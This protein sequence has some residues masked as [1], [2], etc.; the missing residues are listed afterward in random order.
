MNRIM[1]FI[2]P[3][4]L[5]ILA[6]VAITGVEHWLSA[7]G[8]TEAARQALGRTGIAVPYLT[9]ALI[10]IV[11]LFASAGAIRGRTNSLSPVQCHNSATTSG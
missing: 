5:M 1:L 7:F 4:V 9:A 10:G 3:V 11:F 8:K 6:A 2:A